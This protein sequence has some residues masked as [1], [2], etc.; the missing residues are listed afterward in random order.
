MRLYLD[1]NI[2]SDV[3]VKL[4][5][6]ASHD[7]QIPVDIGL[8]GAK[9]PEH[10]TQSIADRRVCVTKNYDDFLR[11]HLLIMQASGQHA[12]IFVARYDNDPTRDLTSK[13]IVAAIRKLEGAGVTIENELIV[14]NHW[15]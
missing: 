2:A 8:S 11:L 12:G 9:D 15:R 7:V 10:L 5:R 13:G 14:L 6:K 4:L 3:L 1:D